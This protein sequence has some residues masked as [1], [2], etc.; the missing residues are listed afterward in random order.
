M[1]RA[2]EYGKQ[3]NKPVLIDWSKETQLASKIKKLV[4]LF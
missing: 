1:A 4:H 3:N 2:S